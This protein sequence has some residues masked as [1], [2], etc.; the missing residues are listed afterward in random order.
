MILP[1]PVLFR[2]CK[3]LNSTSEIARASRLA[4]NPWFSLPVS[5]S[6]E[7]SRTYSRIF[8][9]NALVPFFLNPCLVFCYNNS[10]N[11]ELVEQ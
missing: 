3:A 6:R 11:F 7:L 2:A 4:C 9:C 1:L 8:E 10:A 5:L